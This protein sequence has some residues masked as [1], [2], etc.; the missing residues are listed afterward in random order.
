[1]CFPII[2]NTFLFISLEERIMR[3][4]TLIDLFC[5]EQHHTVCKYTS[6]KED[7]VEPA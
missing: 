1:M 7:D 4:E 6:K 5:S 3:L 2:S